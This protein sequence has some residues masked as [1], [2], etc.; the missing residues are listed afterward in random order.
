MEGKNGQTEKATAK[1]RQDEREKGNVAISQEAISVIVLVVGVLGARFSLPVYARDVGGMM[2]YSIAT[3]LSGAD[4]SGVWVQEQYWYG[5]SLVALRCAPLFLGVVAAGVLG[6]MVQTGPYF[7]WKAFESGGVKALN[8]VK[9]AKQLFSFKSVTKLLMTIWKLLLVGGIA[10]LFWRHRWETVLQLGS[11]ELESSLRWL[12]LNIYYCVLLIV[13]LAISVAAVD[14]VVVF[15][16][17]ERGIM[18][19]KQEVKDEYKQ[20][21]IKPEVKRAQAKK[22]RSLTMSRLLAEVPKASVIVTNPTHVSVAIQYDSEQMAAPRVVAKG[23]RKR[24]LRIREIAGAHGIPIVERPPLARTLYRSVPVGRMIPG[25]LFA[26]VAEVLAY[27]YRLGYRLKG[28]GGSDADS[29][30]PAGAPNS[31]QEL[32]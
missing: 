31:S 22:M 17:H 6:S 25:E 29:P 12:G 21:N 10:F 4:W 1:R 5:A 30:S 32:G 13:V 3:M 11:F 24:A 20:Y 2:R 7:S 18:M 8:P 15:R 27:L 16:R 19:T 26:G 23:L 14:L 28:I 9:G